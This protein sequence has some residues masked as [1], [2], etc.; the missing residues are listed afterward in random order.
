MPA[1][2]RLADELQRAAA[3]DAADAL[4]PL[5]AQFH[6]PDLYFCGHSLGPQPRAAAD[7]VA[8]ELRAWAD[9]AVEGHFRPHR[10]WADYTRPLAEASARLAG[11]EPDEVAV[12]HSLTV[13]LHLMLASF[14]RPQG[15]RV[16]ILIERPAFPSDRYAVVSHLQWHGLDPRQALVEVAPRPGEA[17]L[18]PD[19]LLERIAREGPRLA[20]VLLGVANYYTGQ[21]FDLGACA[22]AAHDAGAL[23]GFDLAHGIGNLPLGL[24]AD[25]ADF[26]VWCGYKYLNGGPGAPAGCFVHRRHFT[27]ARPRLAGWWG[28][29][30]DTRFAMGDDFE[31]EAGAAGWALSCPSILALASLDAALALF[32]RAP[33]DALH[34]KSLALLAL[35]DRLA[36]LHLPPLPRLTPRPHAQRGAQISLA[37]GPAAP[38]V[39]QRLRQAG[40]V[41]DTRG[42]VLRLSFHPLYHSFR[43]VCHCVERLQQALA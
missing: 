14:Y 15:E 7:R 32:Q 3:L 29:R 26:A 9:L 4:A 39:Q 27:P 28:N 6:T 13:N 30:A 5:A 21:V 2:V 17:A 1:P 34:A 40:L 20:L 31:P 43:Q 8:A 12:M 11:A 18:R 16:R 19:D 10:P 35:F 37:L 38:A 33:L 23:A 22:R 24:H 36:D 42:P 25:Q 41:C